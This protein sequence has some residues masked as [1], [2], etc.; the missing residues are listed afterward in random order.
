MVGAARRQLRGTRWRSLVFKNILRDV[1]ENTDGALASILMGYDGI[2]VESYNG[3]KA[4]VDMETVCGEYSQV[5]NQ[6]K[7]AAQM[8]ELGTA[9]EVAVQAENMVTVMRMLN[10][11]YFVALALKPTGNIGKGRFLLRLQSGK[12]LETLAGP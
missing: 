2:T 11:E 1:V 6:V 5:L 4:T 7:Q 3:S 8:L 10:D 12:L 9:T